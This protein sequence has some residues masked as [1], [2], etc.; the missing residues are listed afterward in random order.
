[1][2]DAFPADLV[3][4]GLTPTTLL[5]VLV[6]ALGAGWIDAVVGGGGLLQVPALLLVPGISPVQVKPGQSVTVQGR[7]IVVLSSPAL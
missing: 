5:L 7:S 2:T 3:P 6:A 4:D 1:M